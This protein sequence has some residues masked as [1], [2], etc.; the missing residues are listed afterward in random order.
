MHLD[1]HDVSAW[2][3]APLI[4]TSVTAAEAS[5]LGQ[6]ACGRQVLEVGSAYGY[7]AIVMA[8]AGALVTAVDPHTGGTWLGDSHAAMTANVGVY[9]VASRVTIVRES[10]QDALP[11]LATEGGRFGFVFID[12]D[13]RYEAALHDIE[14][15][16]KLL[17]PGGVLAVHDY[18]ETC[19]C[20]DVAR[21][22]DQLLPGEREL[23]DS[24]LM[25]T[26]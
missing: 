10:S 25:V 19:C 26:R 22:A 21:A 23:V 6:L 9:Q 13:H 17:A 18:A 12:G 8:R 1:W 24:M 16:L 3:G 7:S 11:R 5:R 2:P 20:P 4:S 14:W 15:A